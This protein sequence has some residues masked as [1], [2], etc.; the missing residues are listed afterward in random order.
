MPGEVPSQDKSPSATSILLVLLQTCFAASILLSHGFGR[1]RP[2]G[3]VLG[4]FGVFLGLWAIVAMKPAN[5]RVLPDVREESRLV[6]NGPYRFI[7][8]P[9]YTGLLMLCLGVVVSQPSIFPI[10]LWICLVVTLIAKSRYEERLL[11]RTF[12]DYPAY[13]SRTWQFIPYVI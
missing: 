2:P 13:K 10:V 6:V 11:A 1:P 8:H 9:M 5:V 3:F 12:P 7:R 4:V